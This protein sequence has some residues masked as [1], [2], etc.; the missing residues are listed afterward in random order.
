[1]TDPTVPSAAAPDHFAELA[2]ALYRIADDIVTL[3]GSDLPKPGFV[4]L[5]IQPGVRGNDDL[6][7]RAVDA[8]TSA[9]LGHPGQVA[10]MSN[11]TFHYNNGD[12]AEHVGPVGVRIYQRVSPEFAVKREAAARLA[13]REAEL[14]K[15]R[16]EVAELRERVL[17]T[18]QDGTQVDVTE[19]PVE[20]PTGFV[21][22]PCGDPDCPN[23]S[24]PHLASSDL[25]APD[26]TGLSYTRADT[27]ADDP[28]P[29]SPG[30]VPLH[31][32]AVIDGDEL[33]V[34][35]AGDPHEALCA[36]GAHPGEEC[37]RRAA[38]AASRQARG[39]E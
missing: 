36:D 22:G 32:G 23:A 5:S 24:W 29:V 27:E 16:A 3:T 30:R 21:D 28:T 38:V 12:Y 15:L 10:E 19:E 8:V 9:I 13:E 39:G 37:P 4:Q 33:V 17:F 20:D 1:M 2:A 6:S 26:P 11:G 34:D 7:Q 35:D 18:R 25:V 14:E 31:T